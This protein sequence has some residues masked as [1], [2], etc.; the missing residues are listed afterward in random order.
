MST[1]HPAAHKI[2]LALTLILLTLATPALRAQVCEPFSD[3]NLD[4]SPA[5][6]GDISNF[7][8]NSNQ[9]LQ[10]YTEGAGSS[11]ITFPYPTPDADTIEWQFW[12]RLG[13]TPTANNYSIIALYA[14]SADLLAST[15]S[16]TL[17]VTDPSNGQKEITLFQDGTPL[18]TY[19]YHPRLSNNPLRFRI[20]MV[21]RSQLLM[22]IDTIGADTA[23]FT[24]CG[25][26]STATTAIPDSVHFGILCQYTSSRARLFYFDNIGINCRRDSTATDH[27]PASGDIAINEI[28]FNP[29]DGGADY[30]EFYNR[31]D[32]GI[33][34]SQIYLAKLADDTV[35]TLYPI[36]TAGLFAPHTYIVVTT[37]AASVEDRY[38]VA[39]P[40]RLLQVA[41]MPA[42]GNE[43]G[44]VAIATADS[45]LLDRFDYSDKMHS[46]LLRDKE[47]VALER[48]STDRETQN[49]S[50]W[51]SAASTAGYGTPT[52]RNSQSNE[53][54][55]TDDQFTLS[56]TIFS[57]D[58]DGYNDQLEIAYSL[59]LCNLA[60]NIIVCD[61]QGRQVRTLA[62]GALLG[63]D[64]TLFW[65]GTDDNGRPCPRGRYL[66]AAEL[67][68]ESGARQNWRR[69]VSLVRQ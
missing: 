26:V 51:Y 7:R 14:D 46:P 11:Q 10:L 61:R 8:I 21:G 55:F 54:L 39:H 66:I 17:A 16:M 69:T 35:K 50:N 20:R 12:M 40:D 57:P 23:N 27:K 49:A 56:L 34:L 15:H 67:Y 38:T 43:S 37:N 31:S 22:D 44:C 45:V 4:N 62:R 13:F 63:C 59:Q 25:T 9:Q 1:P 28:L 30:V 6:T 18:F 29:V 3:G 19:P 41:S 24:A 68:N 5:W 58:G 65:D 47:G 36:S 32:I 53:T 64:G 42:Y 52:S 48:R 2:C 60:A 33:P